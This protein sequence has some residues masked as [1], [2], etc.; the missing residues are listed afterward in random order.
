MDTSWL[1]FKLGMRMLVKH[2]VMTL[3]GVVS[4]SL[5]IGVNAAY[6]EVVNDFA[7]PALPLAATQPSG[8]FR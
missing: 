4:T 7:Y 8:F 3:I 6:F 1:D 2:P 5:A